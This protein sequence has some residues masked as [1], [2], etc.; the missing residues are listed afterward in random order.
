MY[1]ALRLQ[2]VNYYLKDIEWILIRTNTTRRF[3]NDDETKR[4]QIFFDFMKRTFNRL[5]GLYLWE[6]CLLIDT[7][8]KYQ[9]EEAECSVNWKT[10]QEK[11]QETKERKLH[12]GLYKK[13]CFVNEITR[14]S[15]ATSTTYNSNFNAKIT[16]WIEASS[17]E[18]EDI[19]ICK[20]KRKSNVEIINKEKS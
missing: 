5:G 8:I 2:W 11:F 4:K 18:E 16:Q 19:G 17:S 3:K 10:E 14:T 20:W 7:I 15:R 13:S 9:F 1:Y 6:K 12:I